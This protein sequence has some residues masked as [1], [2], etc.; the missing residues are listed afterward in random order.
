MKLT[1]ARYKMLTQHV[2]VETCEKAGGA[3]F[4]NI[5]QKLNMKC[6]GMNYVPKLE[7]QLQALE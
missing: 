7:A 2:N 5:I 4:S 1:E 6:Y 3:T